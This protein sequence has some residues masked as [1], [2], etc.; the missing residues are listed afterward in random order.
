M[1][2]PTPVMVVMSAGVSTAR[3]PKDP[4]SLLAQMS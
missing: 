1:P 3:A 2:G 4:K